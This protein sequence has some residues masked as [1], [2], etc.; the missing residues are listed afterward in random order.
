MAKHRVVTTDAEITR[1]LR[2]AK[3]LTD[4]PRVVQVEYRPG[5][6]LDLLILKMSDGRRVLIPREDMEG[7]QHARREEIAEVEISASG[8][9]LHWPR[10]DLDYYVPNLLRH[11]YGSKRWMSHVGRSGGKAKSAAKAEA[12]RANGLKGGRPATKHVGK[13]A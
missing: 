9:A 6:G 8:T 13:A 10:L 3:Q 5:H 4:E 2:A 1:A 7:L 12:A 11:I